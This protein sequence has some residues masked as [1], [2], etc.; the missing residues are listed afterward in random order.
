[1]AGLQVLEEKF[2]GQGFHVLGFLE[3][4]FGMQGGTDGQID[5]CTGMYGVTFPQFA[6]DHVIDTDGAGPE[7]PQP[8]FAWIYAQG[9]P[10]P[11]TTLYPTWNFHKW[12]VSRDGHVIKHWDS[13]T[14][15]GDDPNNPSD[16]FDTSEIVVAIK[17]EL[18]KPKP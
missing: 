5:A 10:G 15:P 14:Y 1:M 16:S 8:V 4:D 17:A 7:V 6:I 11:A 3:N 9:N 2:S 12:L 18:A 13:P